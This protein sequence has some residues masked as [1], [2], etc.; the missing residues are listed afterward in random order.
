MKPVGTPIDLRDC[1]QKIEL[2]TN[3]NP[4]SLARSA[5]HD[6][7][8]F[9]KLTQKLPQLDDFRHLRKVELA[10]SIPQECDAYFEA[11]TVIVSISEACKKLKA[12]IGTGL[13]VTLPRIGPY[14]VGRSKYIDEYDVSWMWTQPSSKHEDRVR[15]GTATAQEMIRVFIADGVDTDG[16]YTLL[17]EL[18]YAASGLPQ[19]EQEICSID[20]WGPWIG[21]DETE[22]RYIKETWE[23]EHGDEKETK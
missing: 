10:I 15:D 22:W 7:E 11:V 9:F 20:V 6:R 18:R 17:D 23:G 5:G 1:A 8:S 4:Q 2:Y 14:D 12:R 19:R 16:G 3:P 21:I 13:K